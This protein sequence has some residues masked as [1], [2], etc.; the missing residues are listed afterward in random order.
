MVCHYNEA[1]SNSQPESYLILS[2]P[3]H[4]V[5]L[6]MASYNFPSIDEQNPLY[7]PAVSAAAYVR[8]LRRQLRSAAPVQDQKLLCSFARILDQALS[9]D[10]H[11]PLD[12]KYYPK[13]PTTSSLS[14]VSFWEKIG[15]L[16]AK[17]EIPAPRPPKRKRSSSF[18]NLRGPAKHARSFV[19]T[20]SPSSF[21]FSPK[22]GG[23]RY[24]SCKSSDSTRIAVQ[25]NISRLDRPGPLAELTLRVQDLEGIPIYSALAVLKDGT[26]PRYLWYAHV[27][28]NSTALQLAP[29]HP[30]V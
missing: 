3:N 18:T 28:K 6:P 26:H 14:G 24:S 9:R 21:T 17:H 30:E 4:L 16:E 11:A 22:R 10:D 20:D 8:S 23:L 5:P 12:H 29:N 27:Q 1:G 19:T 25:R 2:E 7:C 13:S 15:Q